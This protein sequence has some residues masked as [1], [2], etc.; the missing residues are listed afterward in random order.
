MSDL[1]DRNNAIISVLDGV[2]GVTLNVYADD[3]E[4]A[5]L[6][7]KMLWTQPKLFVILPAKMEYATQD[8]DVSMSHEIHI[9]YYGDTSAVF[10]TLGQTLALDLETL[11]ADFADADPAPIATTTSEVEVL[12]NEIEGKAKIKC[13]LQLFW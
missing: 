10:E 13:V 3:A 4:Q 1:E 12:M 11:R 9:F 6:E 8:G 2:V 7:S 5:L